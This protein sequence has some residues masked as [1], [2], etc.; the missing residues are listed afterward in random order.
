MIK[1]KQKQRQ[2]RANTSDKKG[3]HKQPLTKTKGNTME[4]KGKSNNRER[5]RSSER[6]KKYYHMLEIFPEEGE[7]YSSSLSPCSTWNKPKNA[8]INPL[9]LCSSFY[10]CWN[11]VSI[12]GF[13]RP[14]ILLTTSTFCLFFS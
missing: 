2:T 9:Q 6:G 11:S 3:E 5:D 7:I 14:S 1:H 4:N 13:L 12:P 8:F 10:L